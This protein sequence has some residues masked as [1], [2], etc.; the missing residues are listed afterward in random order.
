[1]RKKL[2]LKQLGLLF[3]IKFLYRLTLNTLSAS[4][5]A[6]RLSPNAGISTAAS[7]GSTSPGTT[8][9]KSNY[10][11]RRN[12]ITLGQAKMVSLTT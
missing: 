3:G 5:T 7:S 8:A 6:N 10:S 2:V 9:T 11:V 1:M 12:I 4:S